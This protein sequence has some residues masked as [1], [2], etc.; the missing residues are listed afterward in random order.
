M[1]NSL[2]DEVVNSLGDMEVSALFNQWV[3]ALF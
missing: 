3:V 2:V 1:K